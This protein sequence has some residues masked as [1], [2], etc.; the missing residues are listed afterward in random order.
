MYDSI[1][2]NYKSLDIFLII[3][4]KCISSEHTDKETSHQTE[5]KEKP[6]STHYQHRIL[7]MHQAEYQRSGSV[8]Q[9]GAA[10]ELDFNDLTEQIN[11]YE[12]ALNER[13]QAYHEGTY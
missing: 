12:K 5:Y 4:A 9:G 6:H 2:I 11:E 8:S 3:F 1:F 7:K 10:E 13:M